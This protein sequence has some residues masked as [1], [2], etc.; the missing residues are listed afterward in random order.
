M[1]E[2]K[3]TQTRGAF[4][5]SSG[6]KTNIKAT[7]PHGMQPIPEMPP[8]DDG[9]RV[10][11]ESALPESGDYV[12]TLTKADHAPSTNFTADFTIK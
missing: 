12:V 6:V 2:P 5:L 9:Y 7:L 8:A 10:G 1:S 11:H 3:I 4:F